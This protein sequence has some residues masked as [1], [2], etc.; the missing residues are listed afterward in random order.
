MAAT[1]RRR[2]LLYTLFTHSRKF[3]AMFFPET[4]THMKISNLQTGL[5]LFALLVGLAAARAQVSVPPHA[6][7]R[8]FAAHIIVPQARSFAA[9]PAATV[10][11]T[12]VVVGVEILEQVATTT[13]D[14]SL[15]NPTG[16]RLEAEVVLPVPAG[17][18][19]RGF[20]FQG[21]AAEP[22]AQLLPKAEAKAIYDSIV[23]KVKDPALLEFAGHSLIR[24]SVFPVEAR[25]GQK[26]RVIY[27]HLLAADGDRIDYLL[28]RTESVDYRVPWKISVRIRSKTPV[29]T[30]Y[31]PSHRLET[32][33]V[34][35][36]ALS[37]RIAAD[38]ATEPGAF[39]LSYLLQRNGLTASLLAYPD[40]KI[41]GGYFL[42]LAGAP[43]KAPQH[44]AIK[45]EVVLVLD[46]SG[47]MAGEKLEQVRAA[48]LQV[49]E[50]LEDGEAFNI[51]IFNEAVESFAPEPVIKNAETLR[52]ARAY[53]KGLRVRGGTNIHDALV[54]ALRP[55]PTK[56]F[57]PIVLF[58]TDGLPTVGP[59]SE[60]V[61]RELAA[62]G[63]PFER[64]IFTFGVGVDVNTP[65]LDKVATETRATASFVLPGEDVEVKV[66]QVYKR[67][68]GPVLA[69]P[70]LTATPALPKRVREQMPSRLPDLFEG[71]QLVVLGQYTGDDPVQFL[72][73]GNYFGE[74][75]TF[76]FK[77]ALDQATT[78]NA[79]IP[80]LW[81]SR[82]IARLTD[83]IRD[84]G[85]DSSLNPGAPARTDPRVKE[86]VDEIVRL[87][88]EFGILTEYTA[89]LAKEG[90]DLTPAFVAAETQKNYEERAIKT[91]WGQSSVNQSLNS[92]EQRS[93][94]TL[95]GRNDYWDDKMNRV[96]VSNVQQ[97]N[98]RAFYKRGGRW[99]DSALMDSEKAVPK[100]VVLFGSE[101]YLRLAA[102]LTE[103]NRQGCIALT[104]EILMQVD[105]ETILVK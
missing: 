89:F 105:G 49:I 97:V 66:G 48:A 75:R 34:S 69:G 26:V 88:K 73:E 82:Q 104:G 32:T 2:H 42:L 92:I 23:A 12:E 72:L 3:A 58:L 19:L 54:E 18:V 84:L 86:L 33:R 1:G 40:P 90:T 7:G 25:A 79:F 37:A 47:S 16:A 56:G 95:K 9:H 6:H 44:T 8:P 13:M 99:V 74:Q 65:L 80:R 14:I 76:N 83:A 31:S 5:Q 62:K 4:K 100:R 17:A 59:T 87:S 63:N 96:S 61:I 35:A 98:D 20:T 52:A 30:V 53:L 77:F 55:K 57:L 27:E 64:R 94:G 11:I 93:Q 71:D 103:Q 102:R 51:I 22:T 81:A 39:R 28:P 101:E 15:H 36:N 67:L 43:V 21:A 29:S 85:A 38:A 24:S 10:Q 70:K 50:G 91:R 60:K 78:K 41:G 45:R 46:R 68:I